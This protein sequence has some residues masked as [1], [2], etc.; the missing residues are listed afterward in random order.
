MAG[1]NDKA[2]GLWKQTAR[3]QLQ[4]LRLQAGSYVYIFKL[5]GP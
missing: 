4:F 1:K 3:V 2:G 5:F